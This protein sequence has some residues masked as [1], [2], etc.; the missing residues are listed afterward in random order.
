MHWRLFKGL[1]RRCISMIVSGFKSITIIIEKNINLIHHL[2]MYFA[3]CEVD[4]IEQ[5]NGCSSR[6]YWAVFEGSS[7]HTRTHSH[8]DNIIKVFA[9]KYEDGET[10]EQKCI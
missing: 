6:F 3:N 8:L 2:S 5:L 10:G 1:N 9:E 7:S 4:D